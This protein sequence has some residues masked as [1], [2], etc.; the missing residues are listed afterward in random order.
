[1]AGDW[2]KMRCELGHDPDVIEIGSI[3]GLDEFAVV[4]RLHAIWAWLDQHSESGTN[5]R[6]V[7]AYL[8]RL[9]ACPGFSD[10]MRTVGW[11]SGKDGNLTFPGY[12]NHNGDTAKRRASEAKRKQK[13]RDKRPATSGTNVPRSAGPEKRREDIKSATTTIVGVRPPANGHPP[14]VGGADGDWANDYPTGTAQLMAEV[15]ARINRLHPSWTKRPHW[16]AKEL[17]A[18]SDNASAWLKVEPADWNLLAFYMSAAIPS[19]WRRDPRDFPQPDNRLGIINMGP[20]SI[21]SFADNWLR[22]CKRE[23]IQTNLKPEK[24]TA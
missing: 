9:T 5:V 13:Q 19:E 1:M 18:L 21:L 14:V 11:L 3:L 23:G 17:H 20:S 7:S 15:Q 24:Q 6:I 16:S 4:G 22:R 2:I 10:A 12:E 8:D